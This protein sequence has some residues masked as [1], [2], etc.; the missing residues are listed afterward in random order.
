MGT[1]LDILNHIA[2][3]PCRTVNDH[4]SDF[5]SRILRRE[6]TNGEIRSWKASVVA[7]I[8]CPNGTHRHLYP[9]KVIPSK[10]KSGKQP[11]WGG[12]AGPGDDQKPEPSTCLSPQIKAI[13][14][15]V[16]DDTFRYPTTKMSIQ[17]TR[18]KI[19]KKSDTLQRSV[20][21]SLIAMHWERKLADSMSDNQRKRNE[22][23]EDQLKFARDIARE[24]ARTARSNEEDDGQLPKLALKKK[25]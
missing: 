5:I 22:I 11:D 24:I 6:V 23:L 2:A 14:R 1:P 20:A 12:D 17:D 21:D 16:A 4:I 18:D 3:S 15:V 10:S 8:R 13:D 7:R 19:L 9:S 25:D